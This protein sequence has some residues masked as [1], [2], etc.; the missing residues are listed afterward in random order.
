MP[1]GSGASGFERYARQLSLIGREGQEALGRAR[2]AVVG[3]GGLGS[4][5]ALYLA[6]AGVGE[7]VLVDGDVVEV[8]NLNRQILYEAS[9][10]GLPK[11]V[12]AARRVRA[13]NPG[14]RVRPVQARIRPGSAGEAIGDVDVVVD[15]LDNWEA[16]LAL[17][18]YAWS[19]GIP[20]VHAAVDGWHGQLTVVKR[21][22]TTCLACLA[23]GKLAGKPVPA[24]GPAVGLVGALE[25]LEVLKL[26]TGV[27]EPSYNRLLAVDALTPS[28]EAVELEPVPC[29]PCRER[30]KARLGGR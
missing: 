16:R 2:V 24:I 21:G 4:A 26:V 25:A 30:L 13:L 22:V 6:A 29:E 15:C 9:D 14:V 10:V 12:L 20:L 8:H 28:I 11:A 27:G 19:A 3:L 5:V 23:P 18:E 1:G 17:D 7:L